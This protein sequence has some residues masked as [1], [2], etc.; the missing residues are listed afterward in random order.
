[1]YSYLIGC[2]LPSAIDNSFHFLLCL[3]YHLLNAC[4]VDT[5][6]KDEFI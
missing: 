1:M 5:P 6:I 4:R 2:L 3:G